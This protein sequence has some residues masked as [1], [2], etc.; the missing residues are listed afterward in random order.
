[1]AGWT[2]SFLGS[3]KIRGM[4]SSALAWVVEEAVQGYE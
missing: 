1:L 4:R 3:R 2:C